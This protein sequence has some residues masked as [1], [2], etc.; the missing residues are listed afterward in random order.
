VAK[1][2]YESS[3]KCL[4]CCCHCAP[5]D[6]QPDLRTTRTPEWPPVLSPVHCL[7]VSRPTAA[8]G[9]LELREQHELLID[10]LDSQKLTHTR[11]QRRDRSCCLSLHYAGL[12][13]TSTRRA[14]NPDS[15]SVTITTRR[16]RPASIRL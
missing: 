13:A 14:A 16:M 6:L 1:E 9:A 15:A 10:R 3:H 8:L 12:V 2:Q 11:V 5:W 7:I 4:L